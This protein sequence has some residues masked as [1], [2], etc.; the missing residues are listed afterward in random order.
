M[1]QTRHT[2]R[3][4]GEDNELTM[5]PEWVQKGSPRMGGIPHEP[6]VGGLPQRVS[7]KDPVL[8]PYQKGARTGGPQIGSQNRVQK[9]VYFG[10]QEEVQKEGQ[11][12]HVA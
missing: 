4:K 2:K 5:A 1:T 11:K 10:V 6:F 8:A 9:G 12:H 7:D 3:H